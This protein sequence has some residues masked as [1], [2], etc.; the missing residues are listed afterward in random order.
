M[1]RRISGRRLHEDPNTGVAVIP[2]PK[3]DLLLRLAS[4]PFRLFVIARYHAR[5]SRVSPGFLKE[6]KKIVAHNE[7]Q[8]VNE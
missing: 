1:D 4:F 8:R 6:G 2:E 3:K 7:I 5:T